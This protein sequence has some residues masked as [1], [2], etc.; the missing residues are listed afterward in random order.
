MAKIKVQLTKIHPAEADGSFTAVFLTND[1]KTRDKFRVIIK[2]GL[3]NEIEGDV[4]KVSH[5]EAVLRFVRR[6]YG[7]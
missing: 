1:I 7:K 4:Q 5:I 6:A 2:D 3:V